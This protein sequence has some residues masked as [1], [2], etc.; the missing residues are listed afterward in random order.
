MVHYHCQYEADRKGQ[1]ERVFL[2]D[3][4]FDTDG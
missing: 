3:L 4:D 1:G 2:F